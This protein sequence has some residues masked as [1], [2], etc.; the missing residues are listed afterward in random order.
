[1]T[2]T[3]SSTYIHVTLTSPVWRYYDYAGSARIAMRVR[4]DTHNLVFYLFADHLGSTNVT[5]DPSG[6]LVSLSRY[7]PWG[8]SNG[9]AET[10]LTDYAFTCQRNDRNN[11]T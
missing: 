9:T 1:V 11:V 8:E 2:I 5:S 4:D 10:R 7:K 3:P 6:Q